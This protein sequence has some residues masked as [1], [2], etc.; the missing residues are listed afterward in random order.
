MEGE[1]GKDVPGKDTIRMQEEIE[2]LS[3]ENLLLRQRA[4]FERLLHENR[5]KQASKFAKHKSEVE[6]EI[7]KR[8]V[9]LTFVGLIVV[10]FAWWSTIQPVRQLVRDRL[11]KEFASKNIE[12]LILNA[13]TRAAESQ[14]KG[15]IRETLKPAIEQARGQIQ[16]ETDNMQRFA[17]RL[18]RESRQSIGQVQAELNDESKQQKQSMSSLRTE[19]TK[20]LDRLRTVVDYEEEL[21]GIQVL[22]D[23]ATEGDFNAY[24][25]LS[26]YRSKDLGLMS[27]AHVALLEVKGFYIFANRTKGVSI[28]ML[29]P[30][31]SKG[32]QDG[33]IQV[34]LLIDYFLF[35]QPNWAY[36]DKAAQLLAYKRQRGVAEA[37]L[38]SMQTDPDLWVRRDALRSFEQLTGFVEQD[39]F[40][41]GRA[42]TWWQENKDHYLKTLLK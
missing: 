38:K 17:N 28:W 32:A 1:L 6:R 4:E 33:N 13:A 41:F 12:A 39:V 10:G 29:N 22:K 14:S 9:G 35:N 15:M 20:D 40:D 2:R 30:D 3:A 19:Y 11:N 23:S 36:R 8:L 31:G 37:L 18:Q 27:A 25:Q 34:P 26:E 5:E 21:R 42:A 7:D 24:R 16:Q